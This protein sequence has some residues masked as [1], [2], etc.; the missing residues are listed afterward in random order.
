MGRV[1]GEEGRKEWGGK[2]EYASLALGG[3]GYHCMELQATI[4]GNSD[5]LMNNLVATGFDIHP[6]SNLIAGQRRNKRH[7]AIINLHL[8][9]GNHDVRIC[10]VPFICVSSSSTISLSFFIFFSLNMTLVRP[11]NCYY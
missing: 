6:C 7:K 11:D 2:G 1:G 9:Y 8:I 4:H 3:G 10:S 5:R